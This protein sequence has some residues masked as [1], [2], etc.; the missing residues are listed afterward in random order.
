MINY[1]EHHIVDHCNLKCA[2]CSHFSPI[3]KPWFED[4][5]QLKDDFTALAQLTNSS[6]RTLRIMGGE[7]LLHPEVL[8]ALKIVRELFPRSEVQLV[9]NGILIKQ[10]KEALKN[11][12]NKNNILVCV[13]N[14]GILNLKE[15]LSG[16]NH[17]RID[18]KTNMYN[19][20]LDLKGEQNSQ[21][22]FKN[23]DL[24]KN[25]WY[26]FQNGKMY[27]CCICPNLHI[28]EEHFN[29][30]LKDWEEEDVSISVY[31][32]SLKEVEDFLSKPISMCRFCNTI[33]RQQ[34]Y[35]QFHVS[36]GE[37]TEWTYQ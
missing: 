9:T 11:F 25:R 13:S 10:N 15:V 29:I 21:T 1:I 32:H 2:G 16:F 33:K 28:F 7:P 34:S 27:P 6:I 18:G 36:K 37:I 8:T 22:A 24:A 35:S 4:M 26:F 12:C 17:T 30:S 3:S 5:D 14:Y 19:I 31:N 20:A 23:C